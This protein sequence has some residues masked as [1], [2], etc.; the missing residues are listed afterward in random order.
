MGSSEDYLIARSKQIKRRQKILTLVSIVSFFGS[1]AF[2]AIPAI[3]KAIQPQSPTVVASPDNSLETQAKGF[4]LVLQREPENPVALEGLANI[5]IQLK[6]TQGAIQPLE[7]LVKLRPE[8][9]EYKVMLEQL[10]KEQG[11][12]DR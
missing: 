7:K 11:K 10:K 1:T 2:A 9:Q 8:R 12:S 3:Q 4:E 5:R 6:D